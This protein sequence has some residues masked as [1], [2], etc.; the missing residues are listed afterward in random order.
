MSIMA[1]MTKITITTAIFIAMALAIAILPAVIRNSLSC[2]TNYGNELVRYGMS[3]CV[4][5]GADVGVGR[6]KQVGANWYGCYSPIPIP[7]STAFIAFL[8][9]SFPFH[10]R[11]KKK[12]VLY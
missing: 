6:W 4:N 10:E 11:T 8:L 3:L 7:I 1:I 9:L 12:R 2:S 5:V